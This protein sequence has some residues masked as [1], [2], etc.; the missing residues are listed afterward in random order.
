MRVFFKKMGIEKIR[1]KPAY[2]PYTEV[3]FVSVLLIVVSTMTTCFF[4]AFSAFTGNFCLPSDAK[5]LGGSR[6]QRYVPP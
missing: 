5:S 4:S 6:Q 2:N 3:C 1:F